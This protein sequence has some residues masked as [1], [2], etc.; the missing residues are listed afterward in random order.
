M[1]RKI[2]REKGPKRQNTNHTDFASSSYCTNKDH[3][4]HIS[5]KIPHQRKQQTIIVQLPKEP[6]E[7]SCNNSDKT[8]YG[9]KI[10]ENK[11]RDKID[12][13][14][15]STRRADKRNSESNSSENGKGPITVTGNSLLNSVKSWKLKRR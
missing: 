5:Y 15:S 12:D 1:E 7:A 10:S 2:T 11:S 9:A 14:S 3:Q 13:P 6:P 4:G 8:Q